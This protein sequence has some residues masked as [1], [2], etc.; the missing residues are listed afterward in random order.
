MAKAAK[1]KAVKAEEAQ[2]KSLMERLIALQKEFAA[3]IEEEA[4]K[5]SAEAK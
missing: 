3:R 4:K 1:R 2:P 5:A